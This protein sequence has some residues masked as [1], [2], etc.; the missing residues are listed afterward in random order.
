MSVADTPPNSMR[1]NHTFKG[2]H[3]DYIE[4]GEVEFAITRIAEAGERLNQALLHA[5]AG[6][7]T[8]KEYLDLIERD[9]RSLADR[10]GVRLASRGR[11]DRPSES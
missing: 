7:E 6:G 1:W 3:Y 11:S 9:W 10:Y 5:R 4:K 2:G 8:P